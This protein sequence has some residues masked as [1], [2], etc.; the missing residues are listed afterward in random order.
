MRRDILAFRVIGCARVLSRVQI[1]AG[2][3]DPVR[4]ANVSVPVM[5]VRG[6]WEDACKRVHPGARADSGLA[7][8]QAGRVRIGA[9]RAQVGAR[10]APTGVAAKAAGVVLQCQEGVFPPGLADLFEAIIV[11][12]PGAHSIQVLR[13][14]R[15]IGVLQCEP[16]QRLVAVVT[17]SRSHTQSDKMIHS[18]VAALLNRGQ[19]A[20]NDI[21][22]VHQCRPVATESA[23]QRRHSHG[24]SFAVDECLHLD[25]LHRRAERDFSNQR[26]GV[27]WAAQSIG[28]FF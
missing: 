26:T 10:R 18:V 22:S 2:H 21:G 23:G 3:C 16:V 17:G 24:F 4:C 19:V 1:A 9:A 7:I 27:R 6:R 8:V 12:R 15:V 13:N 25:R 20:H 14:E 28:K 5:I 11:I